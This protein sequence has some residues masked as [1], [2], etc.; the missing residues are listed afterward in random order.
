MPLVRRPDLEE[1]T[2]ATLRT[3]T[4][5]GADWPQWHIG[6][7][8]CPDGDFEIDVLFCAADG[9]CERRIGLPRVLLAELGAIIAAV[10]GTP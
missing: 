10:V 9:E 7:D 1:P 5:P 3:F 6:I 8:P 4:P 2:G